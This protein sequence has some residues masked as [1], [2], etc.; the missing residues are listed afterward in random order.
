MLGS[1]II[2]KKSSAKFIRNNNQHLP[3]MVCHLVVVV[4]L[5]TII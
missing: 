5:R 4:G 3:T 1:V 2:I